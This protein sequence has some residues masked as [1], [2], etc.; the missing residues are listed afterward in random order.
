MNEKQ[1]IILSHKHKVFLKT[2]SVVDVLEGTTYAGKTTI[3]AIKFMLMVAKPKKKQHIIAGKDLGTVIKNIVT[4]DNGILDVF[5]STVEDKS[6][7]SSKEILPHLIYHTPNGDK[8]IYLMG[9]D[10]ADRWKKALGGQYGCVFIDECSIA[11]IHFIREIMMR[12]DYTLMTLNPDDPELD[13]YKEYI[14]HS[15]P[16]KEFITD[17]PEQLYNQLL[18][19]DAKSNWHH[20]YFTFKDNLALTKDK[21]ALILS[22]VAEGTKEHKSKI[23]GLRGRSEGLAYPMFS[24][25]RHVVELKDFKFLPNEKVSRIICGVDGATLKDATTNGPICLTSAG[26][27]IRLPG[28]YYDPQAKGHEPISATLQVKLM[29]TWIDYWTMY[30]GI[31]NPNMLLNVVDSA[32][33]D[34]VLEFKRTTKYDAIAV[35]KKD[36]AVD[37]KRV[38]GIL[39]LVNYFI[40]INAGY[41]D[42]LALKYDANKVIHNLA[43]TEPDKYMLGKSDKLIAELETICID[44]KTGLPEDGNDHATD[45]LKYGSY[46]IFY[47]NGGYS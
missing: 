22:S 23:L 47:A 18:S 25:E 40:I 24:R 11:D 21:L 44:P 46:Y 41:I 10:T 12:C 38:H 19:Q 16:L 3:G 27:A 13:V 34:L 5:G 14:N 35:P 28:F 4:A 45:G 26:R 43:F 36:R 2:Y 1:N 9:Y 30:F 15:R 8:I 31:Y 20:W 42:P 29:E 17:Y 39:E 37:M 7:G 33:P 6:N 32:A